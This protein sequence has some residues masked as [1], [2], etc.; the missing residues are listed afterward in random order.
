MKPL[1][2]VKSSGVKEQYGASVAMRGLI[3]ANVH[4]P[5]SK[6]QVTVRIYVLNLEAFYKPAGTQVSKLA[7]ENMRSMKALYLQQNQE[8]CIYSPA[9]LATEILPY[10]TKIR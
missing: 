8:S 5:P 2:T 10:Y 9:I 6:F 4:P 7:T 1:F 3:E